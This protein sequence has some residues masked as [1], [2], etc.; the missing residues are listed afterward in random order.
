MC[1]ESV[2]LESSV[3]PSLVALSHIRREREVPRSHMPIKGIDPT[4]H[5]YIDQTT[6]CTEA[7]FDTLKQSMP[8]PGTKPQLLAWKLVVL[9]ITLPQ[10]T[11]QYKPIFKRNT[12][13]FPITIYWSVTSQQFISQPLFQM[14][15]LNHSH[16]ST[17]TA[18]HNVYM[19]KKKVTSESAYKS[20]ILVYVS[21]YLYC[22]ISIT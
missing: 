14:D 11:V 6:H 2:V 19:K 16:F 9:T 18:K 20:F 22:V 8:C 5:I 17:E 1:P 10:L 7:D 4:P 13:C 12:I 3:K 21:P 15:F